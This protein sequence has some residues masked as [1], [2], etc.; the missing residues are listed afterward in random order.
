MINIV[1]LQTRLTQAW[2]YARTPVCL[3]ASFLPPPPTLPPPSPAQLSNLPTL[4]R[5]TDLTDSLL[6][7]VSKQLQTRAYFTLYT[8]YNKPNYIS[9]CPKYLNYF[10]PWV[11]GVMSPFKCYLFPGSNYSNLKHNEKTNP[12]KSLREV[13]SSEAQPEVAVE[14]CS[15]VSC[16]DLQVQFSW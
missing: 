15:V 5:W 10:P 8:L 4:E 12:N 1:S 3:S 7:A 11:V 9:P 6:L 13:K 16:W 2:L 14:K